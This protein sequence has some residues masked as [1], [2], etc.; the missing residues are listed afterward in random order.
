MSQFLTLKTWAESL[1]SSIQWKSRVSECASR[2]QL[3]DLISEKLSPLKKE[4]R[5]AVRNGGTA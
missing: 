4:V 5:R 1:D 2:D 3:N